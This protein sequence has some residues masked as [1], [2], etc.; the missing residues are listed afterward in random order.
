M[1]QYSDWSFEP[2]DLAFSGISNG[3][4]PSDGSFDFME[5][6][7]DDSRRPAAI[8]DFYTGKTG[9]EQPFKSVPFTKW[10]DE[11]ALHKYTGKVF[12]DKYVEKAAAMALRMPRIRITPS[13]LMPHEQAIPQTSG[14]W[15][16]S[17]RSRRR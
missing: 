15:M 14:S 6:K 17:I 16:I 11:Y 8:T 5:N 10:Y 2:I 7:G 9:G 12:Y 3:D 13:S 4:R 1:S